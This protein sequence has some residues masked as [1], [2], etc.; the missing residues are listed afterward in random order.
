MVKGPCSNGV[1]RCHVKFLECSLKIFYRLALVE[2]SFVGEVKGEGKSPIK[3]NSVLVKDLQVSFLAFH[4]SRSLERGPER[5]DSGGLGI[6]TTL[7]GVMLSAIAPWYKSNVT[8]GAI[9]RAWSQSVMDPIHFEVL[10]RYGRQKFL[11]R[12]SNS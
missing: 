10:N 3:S 12:C 4:F 9:C 8:R 7:C 11:E 2:S 5:F 1:V 6:T